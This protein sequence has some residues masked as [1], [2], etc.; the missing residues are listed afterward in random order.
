ME[1]KSL[2]FNFEPEL[3]AI[4]VLK[5]RIFALDVMRGLTIF[6][7]IL[8]NNPGSWSNVYAPLLHAKWDGCTPTDLVFPFFM[9]VAGISM[10]V[11]AQNSGLS[12]DLRLKKSITRGLKIIAIG[13]LLNWFPFYDRNIF[14]I[15]IYGV[16]QRIGL[17]YI[18]ASVAV[19]YIPLKYILTSIIIIVLSYWGILMING[20]EEG[21]T[22]EGNLVREIDLKLI[23]EKNIYKGYGIPFDPEGLLSTWPSIATM[24]AGYLVG[25]LF[26][27]SKSKMAYI[28]KILI[29]G[30]GFCTAGYIWHLTGFP[31]NKPIWSG[32]YVLWT[33][34]LASLLYAS[35]IWITDVNTITKWA[36]PFKIFGQNPLVCF[37]LSGMVMK[38]FMRIK[39]EDKNIYALAYTDFF[40]NLGDKFGSL[41]QATSFCALIWL[42]TFLLDKKGWIIKV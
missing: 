14:D 27:T 18:L 15:R 5:E 31:L 19:R 9:F 6:L 22:L 21:L 38:I 36:V 7:M 40:Q 33:A 16:L 17:A 13:L 2:Y 23:G 28:N 29:Y 35:L 42:V 25:S 41:M 39:I 4:T 30:L 10:F 12:E 24:L 8:V 1:L 32:S 34:G 3:K 11:S 26:N 20:T 37:V